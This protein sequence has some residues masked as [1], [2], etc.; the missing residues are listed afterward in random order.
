MGHIRRVILSAQTKK[1]SIGYGKTTTY[2]CFQNTINIGP[3]TVLWVMNVKS[4][5]GGVGLLVCAF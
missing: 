1:E 3:G 4:T 5:S 2:R